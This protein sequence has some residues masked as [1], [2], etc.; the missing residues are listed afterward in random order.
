M[1]GVL[2]TSLLLWPC[3]TAAANEDKCPPHTWA[4]DKAPNPPA[5]TKVVTKPAFLKEEYK[6]GEVNCRGLGFTGKR[7]D[8]NTCK[9]VADEDGITLERFFLLNP[10]LDRAC[11]NIEPNSIYCTD[12]C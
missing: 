12:G 4:D 11:T 6:A 5:D 2:A 9:E 7:V 10:T 8:S 1:I 3:I